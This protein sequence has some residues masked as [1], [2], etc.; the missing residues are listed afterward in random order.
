MPTALIA[1]DEPLLAQ[2][3]QAELARAWPEL[4]VLRTV[5]DG[6]SAVKAALELVPQLLFFDIRMPGLSGLDAALELADRWPPAHAPQQPFPAL[7]FVTA[8]DQYAVQAFEAQ[9]VD[10]LLKPVQPARL[11]KTVSKLQLALAE[12]ARAAPETIANPATDPALEAALSQLRGLLQ[13]H[14]GMPA[15]AADAGG[16][17]PL[18]QVLQVSAGSQI[19]MVP[20]EE[21]LYFEAADK[22]VRVLT[23]DREHLLRT[24]L[25]DLLPQ[26]DP[27]VFWQVHRG[28][29]VRATAIDTVSRDDAGRLTLSLHNRNDKLAVSRLYAQRFKAM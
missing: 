14:T 3:L 5:G 11:Q 20:I 17:T 19:R 6:A 22:Y 15:Q 21:V 28:T 29:V 16:T 9:A 7:V 8:Y 24:A 25:K 2:A 10:Y 23:R 1:E 18:L 27:Q 12:S 26:L 4:Q 13:A